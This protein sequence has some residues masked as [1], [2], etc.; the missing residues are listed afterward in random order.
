MKVPFRMIISLKLTILQLFKLQVL[1]SILLIIE[2]Q[3][4]YKV[5]WFEDFIFKVS[6]LFFFFLG[7]AE[8]RQFL[9]QSLATLGQSQPGRL[10]TLIS[11]MDQ[12]CQTVL[13]GY[14]S[15][16]GVQLI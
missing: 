12:Q 16:F 14:L 15:K 10:P 2:N 4:R 1:N 9:V 6:Y 5:M 8:P 13:Q 3:I 7:V 11:N